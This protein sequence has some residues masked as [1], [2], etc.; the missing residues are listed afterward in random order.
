MNPLQGVVFGL[1]VLLDLYLTLLY[2]HSDYVY[3]R[4]KRIDEDGT[5]V[6]CTK[7]TSLD[8]CPEVRGKIRVTDYEGTYV[9]RQRPGVRT[10]LLMDLTLL[11]ISNPCH[12]RI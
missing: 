5:Y 12:M 6:F 1:E 10:S 3:A 11:I 7:A 4:R 2:L 8:T 9:L